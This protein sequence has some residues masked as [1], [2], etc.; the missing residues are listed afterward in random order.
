MKK[1][2][3]FIA[4]ACSLFTTSSQLHAQAAAATTKG[5]ILV[6]VGV[7]FI[8]D[9]YNGY[10]PGT[11]SSQN[12]NYSN[13]TTKFQLPTLSVSVQ[14]AFWNDITIGG[15]VAFDL[16]ESKL[17]LH[18]VNDYYQ[19]SKYTQTNVYILGRGEYHF[20]RLIKWPPKV[21]LYAGALVGGRI[22]TASTT[23]QYE[24]WG[25]SGQPGSY[26]TNFSNSH[27][28]SGAPAGGAFGGI[29]Y[30]FKGNMSVYAEVGFGVTVFRT[31]LAW[32][33]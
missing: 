28:T 10:Q 5:D 6:D 19:H 11:G 14:K 24:G 33:L 25:T 22:S 17:N 18:D 23:Q 16:G 27:S 26:R 20:N 3:F 2:A 9:N 21:D 29:R 12:W 30:Y 32:R 7:G 1:I 31:G 4:L 8:V 15:Q 13:S